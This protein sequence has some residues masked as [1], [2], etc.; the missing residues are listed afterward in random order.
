MAVTA[1]LQSLYD[2]PLAAWIRESELA[3]PC[4]ECVHVAAISLVVGSIAVVDL[5]LLGL[6]SRERRFS[7]LFA[8]VLPLT[9]GAFAIAAASGMLLFASNAPRYAENAYFRAKLL[10]LALAGLNMLVFNLGSRRRLSAWDDGSNAPRAARLA[11]ALSLAIWIAV[12]A[13]GRW[14]GFTMLAGY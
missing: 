9:W 1:L 7:R 4:I 12:I 3:F 2:T 14:I 13:A 5:R 10:L 6:A 8:D 11:G